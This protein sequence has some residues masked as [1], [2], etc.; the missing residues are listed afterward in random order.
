[1]DEDNT[2][3]KKKKIKKDKDKKDDFVQ[4]SVCLL[5]NINFKVAFFLLLIGMIIFSD[6]FINGVIGKFQ[7]TMHGECTTTKGTILQLI[8]L[9]ISYIVIDLLNK[10]EII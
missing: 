5:N 4:M 3:N 8:F 6:M 2:E 9:V 10:S 1:M 7:N